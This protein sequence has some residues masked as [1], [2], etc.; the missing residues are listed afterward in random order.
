[1]ARVRVQAPAVQVAPAQARPVVLRAPV[2]LAQAVVLPVRQAQLKSHEANIRASDASIANDDARTAIARGQLGLGQQQLNEQVNWRK[3]QER[4]DLVQ[5]YLG[6]LSTAIPGS[7]DPSAAVHAYNQSAL[8]LLQALAKEDPVL[9]H[10]IAEQ[11]K[12]APA[13]AGGVTPTGGP[14]PLPAFDPSKY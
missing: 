3:A 10:I 12:K 13:P 14:R 11:M 6:G 1:V 4:G 7:G 9:A 2:P 8:P 5:R